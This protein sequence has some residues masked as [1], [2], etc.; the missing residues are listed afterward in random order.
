MKWEQQKEH[1]FKKDNPNWKDGISLDREKYE[2]EY[3][4]NHK[5]ERA[6]IAKKCHQKN[7]LKYHKKRQERYDTEEFKLQRRMNHLRRKS[8]ESPIL[9]T[10]AELK[11]LIQQSKFCY[12]CGIK[13]EEK[14][15]IDHMNPLS[16]GGINIITNLVVSCIKC[17]RRKGTKTAE[18]FLKLI[19]K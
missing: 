12:Y 19:N 17:N 11:K 14:F 2:K 10:E 5:K 8:R 16:K 7:Q 1:R 9:V 3:W 6:I 15:E 4:K 18:E 13:I